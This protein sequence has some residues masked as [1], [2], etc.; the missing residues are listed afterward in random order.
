MT[1]TA[2]VTMTSLV[3]SGEVTYFG[4]KRKPTERQRKKK[5]SKI[6]FEAQTIWHNPAE[7][8]KKKK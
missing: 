5:I 1:N 4:L 7:N 3:F 6:D 8:L 2:R